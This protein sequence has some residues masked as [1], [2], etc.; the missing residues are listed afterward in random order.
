M[1]NVTFAIG[2]RAVTAALATIVRY[3]VENWEERRTEFA[4]WL[5]WF[6]VCSR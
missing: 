3:I 1:F 2:D 5:T 6:L 4:E